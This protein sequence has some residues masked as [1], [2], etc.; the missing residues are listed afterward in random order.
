[1]PKTQKFV[2]AYLMTKLKQN[3]WK[4][5]HI[6]GKKVD[7]QKVIVTGPPVDPRVV[8][9]KKHKKV[10][11]K[12][13]L[14]LCL[15]TGGLGTNKHELK[16]ILKQILPELRRRPAPYKLMLYAATHQDIKDMALKLA[17]QERVAVKVIS[18][19][20]EIQ[21]TPDYEEKHSHY[22]FYLIYHPQIVDANELLIKH[23]FPWADGFM[24]KPSGDM[25]YDAAASGAFLLTLKEWGEWEHNI[26]ETFEQLGVARQAQTDH[27]VAQLEALTSKNKSHPAWVTEATQKAHSIDKLYLNGTKNI[28]QVVRNF[29]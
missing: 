1:M 16:Q 14:R 25:A 24:T 26:R 23:A 29:G 15:T 19:P 6:L 4:K 20:I 18:D 27:I 8:N 12:R 13:P 5:A 21:L 7:P 9:A 2:T 3:S 10:W 28:L 17:S 22:N 11:K